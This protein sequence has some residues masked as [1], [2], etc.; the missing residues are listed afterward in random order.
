[1][2][3]SSGEPRVEREIKARVSDPDRLRERLRG[4]GATLEHPRELEVNDIW[5]T[6]DRSLRDSGRVLRVRRQG[7]TFTFTMKWKGTV[8]RGL[9]SRAEEESTVG[10]PA[11]IERI[12]AGL[13]FVRTF[14]YEK[15]RETWNAG[16]VEVVIDQTPLGTFVEIE[17]DEPQVRA[18]AT[19]L[20]I[21]DADMVSLS[22][23][24]LW[25]RWREEHPEA[26]ED[27]L[28]SPPAANPD[29][30]PAR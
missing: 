10:D 1:M 2:P 16:E 3:E 8:E 23:A 21:G 30:S 20:G 19:D 6:P 11:A 29:G 14:R 27:M 5:D 12:L 25:T 22:Y 28:F 24:G 4:V 17:G 26:T 9:K 13:G 7:E 18:M 15:F